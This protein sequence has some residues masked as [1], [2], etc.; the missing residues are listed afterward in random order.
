MDL[1]EWINSAII[2]ESMPEDTLEFRKPET[3]ELIL[4]VVNIGE[5]NE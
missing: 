3:G 5:N 2:D 1:K 4:R